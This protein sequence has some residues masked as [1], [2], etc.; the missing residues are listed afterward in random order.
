MKTFVV[1]DRRR[2]FARFQTQVLATITEIAISGSRCWHRL[3]EKED[4]DDGG[5]PAFFSEQ[6]FVYNDDLDDQQC[7]D[8]VS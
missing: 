4:E 1:R 6:T 3:E 5:D 8:K 7:H 2:Y